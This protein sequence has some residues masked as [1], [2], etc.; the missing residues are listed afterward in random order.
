MIKNTTLSFIFV[1]VIITSSFSVSLQARNYPDIVIYTATW[2]PHCRQ[3]ERYMSARKIPY[4]SKNVQNDVEARK[5][6]IQ[7][8]KSEGVPVIVIGKDEEILRGFDP[9]LF[10]QALKRVMSK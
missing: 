10:R 5:V 1:L 7:K 6:L 3:A 4:V 2:C 8:Y 9:A